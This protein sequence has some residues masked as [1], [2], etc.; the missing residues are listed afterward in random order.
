ME[1]E[2]SAMTAA[3]ARSPASWPPMPSATTNTGA[4]ARWASSFSARRSPGCVADP[5]E[6][7]QRGP[8]A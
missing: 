4:L 1:L 3:L 8:H 6:T 2:N 5:V 7:M